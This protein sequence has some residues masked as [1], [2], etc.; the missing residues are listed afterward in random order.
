M[1][2]MKHWFSA[3][4][5]LLVV[6]GGRPSSRADFVVIFQA[7]DWETA[8]ERALELGRAREEGYLN[9]AGQE[10]RWVL[11]EIV[12]LDQLAENLDGAEV[13]Y[14]SADVPPENSGRDLRPEDSRPAQTL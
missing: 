4:L 14:Q 10:V 3:T 13:L 11:K 12:T 5:R 9:D 1:G 7:I 6:V 8:L 2:E